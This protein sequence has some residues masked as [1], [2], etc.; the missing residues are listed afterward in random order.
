MYLLR[1]QYHRLGLG[2]LYP[3]M[4]KN[5]YVSLLKMKNR[6]FVILIIKVYGIRCVVILLGGIE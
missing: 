5:T 4:M 2:N 3:C 6:L 1:L